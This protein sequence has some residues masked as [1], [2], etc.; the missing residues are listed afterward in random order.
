MSREERRAYRRMTRK[1]DPFAPPA[2]TAA[3]R[4]RADAQERARRPTQRRDIGDDQLLGGRMLWVLT[5]GALT[6]FLLGL[7][8][9][10][11][12]GS[13]TAL[14]AGA[15]AAVGWVILVVAFAIWRRQQRRDA[16]QHA[17][18]SSGR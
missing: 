15:A 17:R 18:G 6:A 3:A 14:L 11:P 2:M 13:G 8:L 4:A 5:G 16:S 10:W 7:S 9:A 12:N 1:Q